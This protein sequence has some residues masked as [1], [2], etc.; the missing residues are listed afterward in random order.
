MAFLTDDDYKDQVKDNVLAT[1]IE[2]TSSLRT[3][4]EL[5]AQAQLTS[6]LNMRYDVPAVFAAAGDA[7][8]AEVVMYMVDVVLYHLHSRLNPGQVPEL[9]KERYQDALDWM[10]MVASGKLEPDLP[11]PSGDLEG[12][13]LD[14]QYGGRPPRQPYY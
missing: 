8:N 4:A 14:V 5:K 11:K 1:I 2:N 10:K 3:K 12:T 9:R 7:R 13:K 6:A